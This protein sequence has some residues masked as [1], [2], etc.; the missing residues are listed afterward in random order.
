MK[1]FNVFV[2]GRGYASQATEY[3]PPALTLMTE[4]HRA[5]GMDAPVALDMGM[6]AL[7]TSFILTDY[8]PDVLA[9]WGVA[10]GNE[11][12]LIFR[13]SMESADGTKTAVVHTMRGKITSIDRGTWV[14]GT[15]NAMTV[16]MNLLYYK[17]DH[18]TRTTHEFD[19]ENMV[20]IVD[21]VDMLAEHRA[22]IGL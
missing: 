9:L 19:I 11:V 15:K 20:R 17:E 18:G 1:F 13:G 21:G 4:D 10:Q 5:G 22:N 6:E 12:P 16:T 7:N 8:N 2:D 3:T 14:P